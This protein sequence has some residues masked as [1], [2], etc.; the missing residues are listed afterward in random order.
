MKQRKEI[1][2][3]FQR[4]NSPWKVRK[5][6]NSVGRERRVDAIGDNQLVF[7][8]DKIIIIIISVDTGDIVWRSRIDHNGTS[9][10]TA[11]AC[12]TVWKHCV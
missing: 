2:D 7:D 6:E 8:G 12:H 1:I 3:I 5:R 10:D 11:I 4:L 9:N